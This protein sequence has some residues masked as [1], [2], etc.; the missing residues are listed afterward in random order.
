MN[1]IS[2]V[3]E[4][5]ATDT[6]S[7]QES[8]SQQSPNTSM[9]IKLSENSE[10]V[11]R[12]EMRRRGLAT[13]WEDT[14]SDKNRSRIARKYKPPTMFARKSD[15]ESFEIDSNMSDITFLDSLAN[16]L[17]NK[18]D[19]HLAKQLLIMAELIV[20]DDTPVTELHLLYHHKIDLLFRLR[21][22][23]R[24]AGD[25]ALHAC[26]QQINIAPEVAD[27]WKNEHDSKLPLHK[28]YNLLVSI[29]EKQ[30]RTEDA[31]E[32][33][34]QAKHQGWEGDWDARISHLNTTLEPASS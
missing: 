20:E 34:E 9:L 7:A 27:I 16:Q 19:A 8:E 1:D 5:P 17:F 11:V 24:Y 6:D 4:E 31:L 25:L 21:K 32:L 12:E 33:A 13:W 14:F 15:D 30:G 23:E 26:L 2:A 10:Y 22:E 18:R 28:G 29:R 3:N